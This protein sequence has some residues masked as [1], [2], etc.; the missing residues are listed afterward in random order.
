MNNKQQT[1]SVDIDELKSGV[2]FIKLKTD[3]GE[4]VKHFVK[5]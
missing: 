2:Y 1:F 5:K 3:R 4:I